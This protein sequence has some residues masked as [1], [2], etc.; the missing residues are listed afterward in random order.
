MKT[1]TLKTQDD[2]YDRVN[3]MAL[4]AHLSKSALIRQAITDYHKSLERKK[5]LNKCKIPLLKLEI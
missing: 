1:I 5:L 3:K 4:E 2:F